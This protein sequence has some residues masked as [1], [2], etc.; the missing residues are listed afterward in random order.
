M[1]DTSVWLVIAVKD[2]DGMLYGLYQID[3]I[4]QHSPLLKKFEAVK[5]VESW[6][7]VSNQTNTCMMGKPGY[8][9]VFGEFLT[10]HPITC[11]AVCDLATLY[12][13]GEAYEVLYGYFLEH[14]LYEQEVRRI[15]C[16]IHDWELRLHGKE[17]NIAVKSLEGLRTKLARITH[18]HGSKKG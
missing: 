3:D 7:I 8:K 15:K 18:A 10:V 2:G 4:S 6:V 16:L 13:I 11:A 12:D 5:K 9:E 1:N 14:K 17:H